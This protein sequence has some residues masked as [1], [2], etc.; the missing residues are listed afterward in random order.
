MRHLKLVIVISTFREFL[1]IEVSVPCDFS[2]ARV[3]P[4]V[5]VGVVRNTQDNSANFYLLLYGI[6]LAHHY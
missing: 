3:E 6:L 2:K 5:A 4:K 1:N